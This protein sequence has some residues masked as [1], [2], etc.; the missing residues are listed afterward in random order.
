MPSR[1]PRIVG[2]DRESQSPS[3]S[4]YHEHVAVMFQRRSPQVTTVLIAATLAMSLIVAV[5]ARS[6]GQ[7]YHQLA[8]L[9][10]AIW[11]GQIWRLVTWPFIQGGPL[12]LIFACV[13][14][15]VFGSDLRRAWGPVGFLRYVAGIVLVVG[16]GTSLLALVLPSAW[17]LPQLGGMVLGDALV[18]AWARLF[19]DRPVSIYFVLIVRGRA[20]VSVI[21]GAT[22][23]FAVFYGISWMLPELLGVAAALLHGARP[24]RRWRLKL[25]RAWTRR[26]LRVVRGSRFDD[27]DEA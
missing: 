12:P 11:R 17:D 5:D 10:E 19:P 27:S 22:V 24:P 23:T 7:L 4:G 18:I 1:L 8:L 14:L 9:P 26:K 3:L 16:I 13:V 6:G 20:L 25:K 21:V 15:H 2:L